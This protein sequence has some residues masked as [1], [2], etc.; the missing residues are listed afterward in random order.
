MI[1][2]TAVARLREIAATA[3]A[4]G[5]FTYPGEEETIAEALPR[6]WTSLSRRAPNGTPL[7]RHG[8]PLP[9]G[10]SRSTPTRNGS[11]P[12]VTPPLRNGT[13]CGRSW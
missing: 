11:P 9:W 2:A 7:L 6:C 5:Y 8:T 1:D 4:A 3:S 13:H 12:N 10:G